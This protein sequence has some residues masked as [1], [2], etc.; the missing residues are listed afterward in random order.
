M[1]E[2]NDIRK[3]LGLTWKQLAEKVDW[4]EGTLR[5]TTSK[6]RYVSRHL[7]KAVRQLEKDEG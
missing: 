5:H 1:Q 6:G 4:S 7:L 2:I 3:R